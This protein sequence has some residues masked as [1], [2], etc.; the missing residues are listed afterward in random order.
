[1]HLTIEHNAELLN[2][3]I[4]FI[5][6]FITGFTMDQI[7]LTSRVVTYNSVL[8]I[9][10]INSIMLS[11]VPSNV[12]IVCFQV[13]LGVSSNVFIAMLPLMLTVYI[14][15]A[16]LADVLVSLT[17][18]HG[19]LEFG[20]S[21]IVR[22]IR[23]RLETC[24]WILR[25]FAIILLLSTVV[26]GCGVIQFIRRQRRKEESRRIQQLKRNRA[27][28]K[29]ASAS[30]LIRS[31]KGDQVEDFRRFKSS[32]SYKRDS[33]RCSQQALLS[34]NEGDGGQFPAMLKIEAFINLLF[35]V[36]LFLLFF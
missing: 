34:E 11:L 28:V 13:I 25:I 20:M 9:Q 16:V 19:V 23:R 36:F 32:P 31:P 7:K 4:D 30:D 2:A 6:R 21:Y 8:F 17:T 1:M 29:G 15:Q 24:A 3:G 35:F 12:G 27:V 22:E 18:L 10:A 5:A 33:D 26:M 14:D